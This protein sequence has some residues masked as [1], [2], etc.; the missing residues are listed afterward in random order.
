EALLTRSSQ[1]VWSGGPRVQRGQPTLLQSIQALA[2]A[3]AGEPVPQAPPVR[4]ALLWPPALLVRCSG[5]GAARRAVAGAYAASGDER[6]GRPVYRRTA[7]F[8]HPAAT[9]Y[10]G[11]APGAAGGCG[12][13]GWWLG[14]EADCGEPWAHHPAT[15]RAQRRA[16]PRCGWGLLRGGGPGEVFVDSCGPRRPESPDGSEEG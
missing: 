1:L 11:A 8:G 14:P 4:A 13:R 16:P 9:L 10:F 2:E 12:P 15:H 5:D 6:E 7:A 3:A